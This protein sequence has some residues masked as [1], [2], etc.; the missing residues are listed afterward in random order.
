VHH[1][2]LRSLLRRFSSSLSFFLATDAET[3][4]AYGKRSAKV[5]LGEAGLWS[6]TT[7]A[8]LANDQRRKLNREG[9]G[10]LLCWR[11]DWG[12]NGKLEPLPEVAPEG[13]P[14]D[15]EQRRSYILKIP[16]PRKIF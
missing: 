15:E 5:V 6:L 9:V 10:A 16:A 13:T 1:L 7:T 3:T 11:A 14:C 8:L 12:T 4:S 2:R